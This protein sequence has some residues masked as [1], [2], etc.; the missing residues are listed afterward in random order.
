[1]KILLAIFFFIVFA[2]GWIQLLMCEPMNWW[3]L[4]VTLPLSFVMG[5]VVMTLLLKLFKY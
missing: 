2:T 1:M 5:L 4:W 3:P